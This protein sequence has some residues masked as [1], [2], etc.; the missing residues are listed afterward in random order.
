VVRANAGFERVIKVV[1]V[2][3]CW[4]EC[5]QSVKAL[6]E[7]KRKGRGKDGPV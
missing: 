5:G 7:K 1:V 3:E 6:L 4:C 2:D